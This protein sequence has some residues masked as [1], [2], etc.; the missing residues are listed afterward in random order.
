M[1]YTLNRLIIFKLINAEGSMNKAATHLGMNQSSISRALLSLEENL[2]FR[3]YHRNKNQL[4]LTKEGQSLLRK[5]DKLFLS[6]D[7]F[8][9]GIE[10][11]K[12]GLKEIRM[13]TPTGLASNFMPTVIQYYTQLENGFGVRLETRS[14]LALCNDINNGNLD[15]ALV[16]KVAEMNTDV[17]CKPIISAP[18]VCIVPISSPLTQYKTLRTNII[19]H[20]NII[21]PSQLELAG[22]WIKEIDTSIFKH[23]KITSNIASIPAMVAQ[24][25][26]IAVMNV[27]TAFDLSDQRKVKIIPLMP[28]YDLSFF[29]LYRLDW[30]ENHSIE[31]IL[32]AIKQSVNLQQKQ[33]QAELGGLL[34]YLI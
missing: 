25:L 34:K 6:I 23:A 1:K 2:G 26:G 29:L 14:S 22:D 31:S 20:E 12:R 32:T 13:G 7:Q 4:L 33:M 19:Q 21:F 8:E 24:G 17:I 18:L 5:M 10:L 15:V 30:A 3:L 16:A 11:I 28:K 27:I 9:E